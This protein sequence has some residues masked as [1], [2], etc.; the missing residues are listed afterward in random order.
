MDVAKASRSGRKAGK[1]K[2][3]GSRSGTADAS[4]VCVPS[5]PSLSSSWWLSWTVTSSSPTSWPLQPGSASQPPSSCPGECEVLVLLLL[6]PPQLGKV[7]P[8][9]AEVVRNPWEAFLQCFQPEMGLLE[10]N[11]LSKER[12]CCVGSILAFTILLSAQVHAPRCRRRLQAAA[13]Q[14]PWP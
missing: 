1:G 14:L 13:P 2:G 10:G 8:G 9:P 7:L 5:L 12:R 6:H 4:L 3:F 11:P